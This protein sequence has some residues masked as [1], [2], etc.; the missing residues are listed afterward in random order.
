MLPLI[1][2]FGLIAATLV[3]VT[4]DLTDLYI[5]QKQ[6]DALADAAALAGADGFTLVADGT[7]VRAQLDDAGVRRSAMSVLDASPHD[8]RLVS[9]T[10]S[11]GA[12]SSVTVATRWDPP[13]GSFVVP[14]GVT[15]TASA[16]GRTALN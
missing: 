12:T 3:I 14:G 5:A 16:T 9:A 7:G 4:V 1:I 10:T 13:I 11:D 6:T 15:L 8:A 2:G